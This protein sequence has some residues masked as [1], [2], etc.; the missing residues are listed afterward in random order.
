MQLW[1]E[2]SPASLRE[3]VRLGAQMIEFDLRLSRDGEPMV[4]HDQTV[5]RM[6]NGSGKIAAMTVRELKQLTFKSDGKPLPD[7][8]RILTLREVLE[9]FPRNIWL[10]LHLK[11]KVERTGW[12]TRLTRFLRSTKKKTAL[13]RIVSRQII[14]SGRSHQALLTCGGIHAMAAREENGA[15]QICYVVRGRDSRQAVREAIDLRAQFIQ[16]SE[17]CPPTPDLVAQ[18]KQHGL[19]ISY[20]FGES[21]E[22]A[23]KLF[24][25][26]VD[27]PLANN[28]HE[29]MPHA[30]SLGLKPVS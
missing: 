10:N 1:P 24:S 9:L 11:G 16:L 21:P 20:C 15:I 29:L 13:A 23:G 14:E 3:A 19:R 22:E 6:T 25:Q 28:I 5:D 18:L 7:S 27:F 8:E 17:K 30:A 2:N 4:I 26:G 12:Q